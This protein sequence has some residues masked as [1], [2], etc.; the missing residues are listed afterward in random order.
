M[1]KAKVDGGTDNNI[2]QGKERI[3]LP[4]LL[5]VEV[6]ESV[7]VIGQDEHRGVT[8]RVIAPGNDVP[9]DPQSASTHGLPGSLM[10]D[11]N[12]SEHCLAMLP[13][14]RIFHAPL[15]Q[16]CKVGGVAP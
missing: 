3:E 5:L 13:I 11:P 4:S 7:P 14:G 10:E 1:F 8:G 6:E 16:L 9:G 12:R 15:V 2:L